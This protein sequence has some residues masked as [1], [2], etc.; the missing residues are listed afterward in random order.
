M[1][2]IISITTL[3]I[4]LCFVLMGVSNAQHYMEYINYNDYDNI[5]DINN[6]GLM[7]VPFNY[8]WAKC[9]SYNYS[10]AR[11]EIKK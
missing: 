10:K 7:C 5:N 1:K 3:V 9:V 8:E 11:C 6:E 2:Q 4:S